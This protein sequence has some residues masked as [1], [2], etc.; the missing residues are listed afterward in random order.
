MDNEQECREA[1]SRRRFFSSVAGGA[2]EAA[3]LGVS[4]HGRGER[5]ERTKRP[6]PKRSR[7]FCT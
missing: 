4:R 3:L 5:R 7:W 2:T 6:E 1:L